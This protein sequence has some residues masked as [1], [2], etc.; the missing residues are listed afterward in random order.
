MVDN[1]RGKGVQ[2]SVLIFP[3]R[4]VD[5]FRYDSAHVTFHK[6]DEYAVELCLLR[7]KVDRRSLYIIIL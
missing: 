2:E 6:Y 1:K 4:F 5:C 7:W 3:K